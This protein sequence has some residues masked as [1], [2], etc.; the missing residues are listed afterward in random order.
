MALREQGVKLMVDGLANFQSQMGTAN[1]S[2][3]NFQDRIDRF[4]TTSFGRIGGLEKLVPRDLMT[5][6][7]GLAEKVGLT[8]KTAAAATA[9]WSQYGAALDFVGPQALGL[10]AKLSI[11]LTAVTVL[12]TALLSLGVRGAA[13]T[14]VIEAFDV[15]ARHA[16][17]FANVLLQDLREAARGTI[18]D[19]TLMKTTNLALAGAQPALAKALGQ[20]GLAGLLEIARSQAR[21]TGQE[22]N[23]LY[24]S[25]VL[26]IKRSSPRLID[27]TGLVLK[28]GEANERYARSIGKTVEQLTAEEKQIAIL[29]ATLAQGKGAVDAY[30]RTA[31]QASERIARIQVTIT[32]ALDR[33]AL[34][35]QPLFNLFLS[36]GETLLKAVL[37]PL[38]LIIPVVYALTNALATPLTSAFER[39]V[40]II[41]DTF[42]PVASSLHRWLIVLVGA[43]KGFGMAWDWLL[44]HFTGIIGLFAKAMKILFLEPL[45][46]MLDPTMYAKA[47]GIAIGALAEGILWAANNFV[48][49]AIYLIAKGIADLLMGQSPPP[50]GP[51]HT[52]DQ[53]GAATMLAWLEGFTGVALTPVQD[54]AQRVN[55]EL[56]DIRFMS[57]SQVE[58][59]LARLD[60]AVQ[61]FIDNLEI[62]KAKF[63]EILEPLRVLQ[64]T[65]ERKLN[66]ALEKFFKGEMTEDAVR[67]ID[68]QME[69]LGEQV[70]LFED[71]T[72]EAEYQVALMRSQQALQRALLEIQLRRTEAAEDETKAGKEKIG[73]EGAAPKEPAG[74]KAEKKP[75]ELG[76]GAFPG[77]GADAVGAFLGVSDDEIKALFGEMGQSFTEGLQMTGA[78][79]QL[80]IAKGKLSDIGEQMDRIKESDA[81]KSITDVFDKVFGTGEGSLY[82]RVKGFVDNFSTKWNEFDQKLGGVDLSPLN[83]LYLVLRDLMG[84]SFMAWA[85]LATGGIALV[86]LA[87]AGLSFIVDQLPDHVTASLQELPGRLHEVLLQPFIDTVTGIGNL[88]MGGGQSRDITF[89]L[90]SVMRGVEGLLAVWLFGLPGALIP[91]LFDPFKNVVKDV[92]NKISDPSDPDS[93]AN[94]MT[95]IPSNLAAWL[96]NGDLVKSAFEKYFYDPINGVILKVVSAFGAIKDIILEILGLAGGDTY[97][98]TASASQEAWDEMAKEHGNQWMLDHIGPRPARERG[99][100]IIPGLGYI[101]GE[102]GWE[103]FKPDLPG[104]IISHDKSM[105]MLRQMMGRATF[106][107]PMAPPAARIQYLPVGAS[108]ST[109]YNTD[110]SR[111]I[112]NVHFNSG[113]N[114]QN[115][116]M[117]MAAMEAWNRGGGGY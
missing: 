62:A 47:G 77:M 66:R 92:W 108:G 57:H 46:K 68:R 97:Q 72:T 113:D 42:A 99:G 55:E 32:N 33:A 8:G 34:S 114:P 3:L 4:R 106:P 103:F 29:N 31:L 13:M 110:R 96:Q 52:I 36:V 95:S 14:G 107:T 82:S 101:V 7:S 27:N 30:G 25:L 41:N 102:K 61:P 86:G 109:T 20:G 87:L 104:R 76:G 44:E 88:I 35:I 63:E 10:A 38:Q 19:L 9:G 116:R 84:L 24:E 100:R 5:K 71:M 45:A 2:I 11:A 65:L 89:T 39:L 75:E 56:G 69:A 28:V 93:L 79:G 74:G 15:G 78:E 51:L 49:P 67:G 53:G 85:T 80:E 17:T 18:S 54:M 16:G 115:I 1:K 48:F 112:Q 73:K 91:N 81:F 12:A 117:R 23:Y 60:K 58:A 111:T 64:D 21:A 98:P 40:G 43:I 90:E 59:A 6:L 105:Q 26:G 83:A 50:K 22:V 37:S 94:S 70:G